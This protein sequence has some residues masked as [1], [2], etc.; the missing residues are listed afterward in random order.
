[1]NSD[2]GFI[3]LRLNQSGDSSGN[4]SFWPSFTDI[5]TVIVMIFLIAMVVLLM[6]NMELVQ[7]LRNTMEAER[8]AAELARTTGEEKDSLSVRLITTEN[9]LSDL[10][11][12]LMQLQEIRAKQLAE[13]KAQLNQ[14]GE[15]KSDRDQSQ[16]TITQ[17]KQQNLKLENRTDQLSLERDQ[18]KQQSSQLSQ[19]LTVTN[20]QMAQLQQVLAG[21]KR[22]QD[23][24]QQQYNS[25]QLAYSERQQELEQALNDINM[26]QEAMAILRGDYDNLK[27][28]YD[29]LVRPARTP[30]GKYVVEVRY[31][32][33]D[34]KYNISWKSADMQ[35]FATISQAKLEKQLDDLKAKNPNKLYI[36]VIFPENS[37]LSYS[38]A[39]EFTSRLHKAY[40]YYFQEQ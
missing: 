32:K 29:K 5:M 19:Q 2:N 6:R 13:L 17:L 37:G 15:L 8:M 28:K 3:N 35:S 23:S 4:E 34:D 7:Q 36:K 30:V 16:L 33:E 10:R 26:S 21:L 40:D 11:L 1:M 38:E 12:Q 27:V 25:L 20:E 22:E 14:I 24:M 31:V 18:L 9:E 39:W